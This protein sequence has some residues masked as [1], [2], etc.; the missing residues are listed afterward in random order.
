MNC[1]TCQKIKKQ[2]NNRIKFLTIEKE[3][4]DKQ[5]INNIQ[6]SHNMDMIHSFEFTMKELKHLYEWID[7]L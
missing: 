4:Y 2:I 7:R 1:K 3:T 6:S 5:L